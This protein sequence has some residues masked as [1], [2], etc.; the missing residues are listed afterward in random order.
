MRLS[1]T[2]QIP[3]RVRRCAAEHD[4]GP[5]RIYYDSRRDARFLVFFGPFALLIGCIIFGLYLYYYE[6]IFSWWPL[7]QT[8]VILLIGLAWLLVGIWICLAPLL[9]PRTHVFLCPGGLVYIRRRIHAIPWKNIQ[10]IWRHIHIDKRTDLSCSYTLLRNDGKRFV[11]DSNLPHIDR[12]G[13]FLERE[14]TRRLL[15]ATLAAY[16]MGQ[17]QNFV[18]IVVSSQGLRLRRE[19]KLLP[20]KDIERLTIDKATASIYRQ[21][22]SWEW[23]AFS[24]SGIPNVGVLKG[25]V[26]SVIQE[27]QSTTS[28]HIQA[29]N[30]GFAV[31]F[32]ALSIN[33]V[34]ISVHNGAVKLPWNEIAS[35]ALG[36]SELLIRR[37][38]RP[39]EWYTLPIWLVTDLP[40]LQELIDYVLRQR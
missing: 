24:L 3:A 11:L 12:L 39:D 38:G 28:P 18:E 30:A 25:L 21:G 27:M 10:Q 26:D 7:W 8:R 14:V 37:S 19:P 23:A 20:W 2:E 15:P 35:I 34:G 9:S 22:D 17:A 5:P 32:G 16:K 31:F 1:T 6:R 40:A 33:K 4:L 36:E 29:Y 13:G